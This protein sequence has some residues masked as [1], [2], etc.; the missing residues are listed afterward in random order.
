MKKAEIKKLLFE[1]FESRARAIKEKQAELSKDIEAFIADYGEPARAVMESPVNRVNDLRTK[2]TSSAYGRRRVRRR[3]KQG[4][5]TIASIL[6]NCIPPA[7]KNFTGVDREFTSRQ[8]FE[9]IKSQVGHRIKLTHVSLYLGQN[10]KKLGIKAE[11]RK[12]KKQNTPF[13]IVTN[14]FT[15]ARR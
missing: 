1:Q 14:F 13:P 8:I 4:M 15:A 5:P 3:G 2:T 7:V 9:V 6:D 11:T 10:K 12:V